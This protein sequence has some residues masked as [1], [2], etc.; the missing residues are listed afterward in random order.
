MP[1]QSNLLTLNWRDVGKG[2]ITAALGAAVAV[3]QDSINQGSLQFD[4]KY[5]GGVALVGGIGYLIKNFFTKGGEVIILGVDVLPPTGQPGVWYLYLNNYYYWS[6][7]AWVNT[8]GDRPTQ[9][10]PNP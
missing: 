6:G 5:I 9:P 3:I 7:S 4:W 1:K 8:G 10:P 2:F